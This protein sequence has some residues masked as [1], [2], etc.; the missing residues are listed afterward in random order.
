MMGMMLAVA[1]QA[2]APNTT[3]APAPLTDPRMAQMATLYD[4]ICLRAF[5]DDGKLDKVVKA[6][7]ATA[8]TPEEVRVTLVDDP[9]RGWRIADPGGDILVILEL[10]PYHACSVRWSGPVGAPD[11]APYQTVIAPYLAARGGWATLPPT[12]MDRGDV[13]ISATMTGRMDAGGSEALMIFDQTPIDP[14]R[15]A[16]PDAKADRRFVHQLRAGR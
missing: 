10:P 5:P 15:R 7:G 13:H 14:A 4:E 6:K 8:L 2:T 3:T 12:Q 16:A 1:A 9:G 11:W